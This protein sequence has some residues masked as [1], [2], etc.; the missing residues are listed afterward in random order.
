M[1]A[2]VFTAYWAACLFH[3]SKAR[4]VDARS[5]IKRQSLRRAGGFSRELTKRSFN[6]GTLHAAGKRP[7]VPAHW[8]GWLFCHAGNMI[9]CA[10]LFSYVSSSWDR[11]AYAI[12]HIVPAFGLSAF[13]HSLAFLNGPV[14]LLSHACCFAT[15]R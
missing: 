9:D 6:T 11:C 12:L 3:E 1:A 4:R 2:T 15:A 10:Q 14:V 8:I 7:E 5:L 13:H